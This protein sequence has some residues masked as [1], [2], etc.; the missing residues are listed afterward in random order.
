[1]TPGG[2]PLTALG[3]ATWLAFA[4][5]GSAA[6]Q[7]PLAAELEA[8]ATRYHENP[9]RL[10][11][12]R[13]GLEQAV[14]D[15]P[16]LANLLALARVS[17]IWAEV[18][19]TTPEQKLTA[20]DRGR[21]AAR[22]AVALAP[23][24]ALAHLWYGINTGRWGQTRGL[25]RSL[26][27]LPTVREEVRVT[28]ELDPGLVPAY[29]LAGTV[30]AEVPGALGGDLSRA[31]AM[32]RAGLALDPRFTSLRVGLA[33]VLVRTSRLAE[34]RRELDA[35]LAETAPTNPADWAMRDSRD[36]RALLASIRD[37]S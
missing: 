20:Y 21:E 32:F 19:A 13:D 10:D 1:M 31:E 26:F 28:L 35:V 29:A 37:R 11:T 16:R 8:F 7:S 17:F 18:R 14:R 33:K 12:L 25:A 36:A 5:A 3:L 23:R 6:A 34:A 22:R 15:D 2:R 9:A 24:S 30:Y 27:L 4:A